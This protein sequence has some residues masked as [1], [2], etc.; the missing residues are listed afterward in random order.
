MPGIQTTV[1]R[2]FQAYDANWRP[3]LIYVLQEYVPMEKHGALGHVEYVPGIRRLELPD[4]RPISW[5]AKG[6]YVLHDGARDV[7][8]VCPYDPDAP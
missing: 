8:L 5:V 1:P 2:Q 3:Y 7:P 6:R 4:G